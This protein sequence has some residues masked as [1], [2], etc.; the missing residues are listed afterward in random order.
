[1]SAKVKICR[2]V[3]TWIEENKLWQQLECGDV[4][5]GAVSPNGTIARR[6]QCAHC[7]WARHLAAQHETERKSERELDR[8]FRELGLRR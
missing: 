1:M 3:R 4:V 7:S 5:D 8:V 2:V 6:R